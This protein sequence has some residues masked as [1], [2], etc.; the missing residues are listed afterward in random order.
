MKQ[1]VRG[2]D[3]STIEKGSLHR[4]GESTSPGMWSWAFFDWGSNSYATIVLTFVFATY[5]SQM[6]AGD[7]VTGAALWATTL[8]IT[9]ILVGIGGPLLGAIVDQTGRRKPWIAGFSLVCILATA[10]LWLVKPSVEYVILALLLVSIGEIGMEYAGV[11]YNAMLPRLANSERMGRWSGWGWSMGYLGG[12]MALVAALTVITHGEQ[13]FGL[14]EQTAE[15]V[16]ATF[17]LAAA[18]FALFSLPMFLFTPDQPGTGKAV[19]RAVRDGIRQLGQ[20]IRQAREYSYI[21]R[22]L[23]AR[24]LYIDGLATVFIFGGVY[25]AGTFGMSPREVLV[26]GIVVNITAGFGAA[27]FAWIDDWFGSK[28]TILLSLSGLIITGSVIVLTESVILFWVS[29]LVLGIFVGP[30]QAASRTYM[31]RVAPE[32]LRNQMFGLYALSGKVAFFCPLFVGAVTYLADSQRA[33]M[34]VAL[35]FFAAGFAVLLKVPEASDIQ[36]VNDPGKSV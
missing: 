15:P 36:Q 7:E 8:G 5:F 16:R 9:G 30:V 22:F 11:F 32:A 6:V 26:F 1:A 2:T 21:V 10:S 19:G 18:W 33:G 27:C 34:S 23:I 20:S 24:L 14:D 28:K 12:L 25:A 29:A 31:G 4:A 35:F 13:W 3:C 17:F